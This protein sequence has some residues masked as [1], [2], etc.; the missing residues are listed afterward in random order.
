MMC[1]FPTEVICTVLEFCDHQT[2]LSASL[3]NKNWFAA[4]EYD[5]L[6]TRALADT[7]LSGTT[8]PEKHFRKFYVEQ[9]RRKNQVSQINHWF[10]TRKVR[11]L[12]NWWA[13]FVVMAII[14]LSIWFGI[15]FGI[16]NKE[17]RKEK[18]QFLTVDCRVLTHKVTPQWCLTTSCSEC[19]NCTASQPTCN[20]TQPIPQGTSL[21]CCN[22]DGCCGKVCDTCRVCKCLGGKGCCSM[23]PCNCTCKEIVNEQCT[24]TNSTCYYPSITCVFSV[25]V[26]RTT[27]T[28]HRTIPAQCTDKY[29]SIC[30]TQ[31]FTKYAIGAS[32]P[33]PYYLTPS[34]YY[35]APFSI[36][37]VVLLSVFTPLTFVLIAIACVS[38]AIAITVRIFRWLRSRKFTITIS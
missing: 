14:F 2:L 34:T 22:G 30:A 16:T 9:M 35:R 23:Q 25:D 18:P 27:V 33:V 5:H 10:E 15:F 13:V 11:I 4:S 8:L 37:N 36:T 29:D 1:A 17:I 21:S 24:I 12:S 7:V 32:I 19:T 3:V 31:Y 20:T 38:A 28:Q 26:N 6:W